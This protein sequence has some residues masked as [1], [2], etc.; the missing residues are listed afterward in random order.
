[1][2]GN[3][4][5]TRVRGKGMGVVAIRDLQ[6]YTRITRYPGALR[7]Y[8]DF[9]ARVAR[10]LTTGRYAISFFGVT[11]TGDLALDR[12]IDPGAGGDR[13][14]ARYAAS[15]GP[16]VNEPGTGGVPNLVWVWNVPSY[17]LELWTGA[18]PV[19]KNAELTVCYGMEGGYERSYTT[20]CTQPG[21]EPELHVV[22]KRGEKP[23]P[24]SV[25]GGINAVRRNL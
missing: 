14:A 16:R 17:S 11:A 10:G 25:A 2:V 1:M 23:R 12:V 9:Q 13:L 5:L 7:M 21:T 20:P 15:L 3:A 4:R 24:L 8:D 6:P 18:S 19:A 22:L